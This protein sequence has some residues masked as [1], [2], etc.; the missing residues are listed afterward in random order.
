MSYIYQEK[1]NIVDSFKSTTHQDIFIAT[2][3]E[4][5]QPVIINVIK[6]P[7]IVESLQEEALLDGMANLVHFERNENEAVLVT[8]VHDA[9]PMLMYLEE[10][11]VPIKYRMDLVFQY[12]TKILQ[13]N[14]LNPLIKNILIDEAQLVVKDGDLLIDELII[15]SDNSVENNIDIGQK[16][17]NVLRKIIFFEYQKLRQEELLL[18]EVQQFIDSLEKNP[19]EVDFKNIH[20][21]FRKLYIY[22]YCMEGIDS[23][24]EA[25]TP[26]PL[27]LFEPAAKRINLKKWSI[28]VSLM[29][30]LLLGLYGWRNLVPNTPVQGDQLEEATPYVYFR[31]QESEPYWKLINESKGSGEEPLEAYLWE[32]SYQDKVIQK[33]E[34]KDPVLS[35]NQSGIYNISLMVKDKGAWSIPYTETLEVKIEEQEVDKG[36]RIDYTQRF[37]L[38]TEG[39]NNIIKDN[40]HYK[41]EESS[42]KLI[43]DKDVTPT[44]TMGGFENINYATLAM[45]IK[46]SQSETIS[47]KLRATNKG[48]LQ[49]ENELSQ[50]VTE[51]DDWKLVYFNLPELTMD[52]IKI[53]IEGFNHPIWIDDLQL[54]PYK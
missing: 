29:V 43:N 36:D 54:E 20:H 4:D 24:T 34:L 7:T 32:I 14:N 26:K 17:A 53:Q 33:S 28:V 22:H 19:G 38:S 41:S 18:A 46:T 40:N 45:L 8:R 21:T 50:T 11:Y 2:F 27:K 16:V 9:E 49:H 37:T 51:L 48:K 13:Y 3:K 10:N 31:I 42:Y 30:L 23:V 5:E 25:S 47:I 12:L 39:Q 6:D 15:L 52:E 44:F 1:F 35:F